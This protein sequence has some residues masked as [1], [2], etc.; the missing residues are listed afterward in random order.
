MSSTVSSSKW[1]KLD[2]SLKFKCLQQP[3]THFLHQIKC[4]ILTFYSDA[5]KGATGGGSGSEASSPRPGTASTASPQPSTAA[6]TL[7]AQGP[8]QQK[9]AQAQKKKKKKG[10]GKWQTEMTDYF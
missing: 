8:R 4:F 5:S 10:G 3:A 7:P 2:T 9:P 6:S 1:L